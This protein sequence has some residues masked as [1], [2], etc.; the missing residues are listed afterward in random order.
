MARLPCY[1]IA[2]SAPDKG[3]RPLPAAALPQDAPSAVLDED[4]V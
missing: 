1:T 3:L 4:G 2:P